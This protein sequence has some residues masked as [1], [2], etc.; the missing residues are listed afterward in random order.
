MDLA[1]RGHEAG[2]RRPPC[3]EL[4]SVVCRF[5]VKFPCG[6]LFEG[7][8]VVSS[9]YLLIVRLTEIAGFLSIILMLIFDSS[10][11]LNCHHRVNLFQ[12]IFTDQSWE[13]TLAE[14]FNYLIAIWQD[15]NKITWVQKLK[16]K[17]VAESVDC[18]VF[19]T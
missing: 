12:P 9:C 1:G 7:E 17:L 13:A 3:A 4:V 16:L 19:S 2:N 18:F 6:V 8:L 5:L 11:L 10:I 15:L 14:I